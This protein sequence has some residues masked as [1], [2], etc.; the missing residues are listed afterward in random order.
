MTLRQKFSLVKRREDHRFRSLSLSR[1]FLQCDTQFGFIALAGV[2]N[3]IEENDC[4]RAVEVAATAVANAKAEIR[5][6]FAFCI[7][8]DVV[9][10]RNERRFLVL[11]RWIE[12]EGEREKW[13]VRVEQKNRVRFIT[14]RQ[15]WEYIDSISNAY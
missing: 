6:L 9:F 3:R 11:Q 8:T 13:Y 14:A 10:E 5:L 15:N 4:R 1:I 12:R 7:H 2:C